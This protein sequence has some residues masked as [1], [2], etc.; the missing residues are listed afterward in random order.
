MTA[1]SF[2]S[3]FIWTFIII[4]GIGTFLIRLS[5]IQLFEYISEV[6]PWLDDALQFVPVAILT[7]LI[8]PH[9]LTLEPS[10]SVSIAN[11]RLLAGAAAAVVAWRTENI[12][13]TITVGMGVLW[14]SLFLI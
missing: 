8:L 13:A 6:P 7:A 4:V 12:L 3:G 1:D 2:D 9:F 11:E 14:A 10:L 5:F